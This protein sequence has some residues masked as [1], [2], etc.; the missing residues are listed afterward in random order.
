ML[1]HISVFLETFKAQFSWRLSS[2][3]VMIAHA[4][5]KWCQVMESSALADETV[6]ESMLKRGGVGDTF[7]PG[8]VQCGSTY[9]QQTSQAAD[10]SCRFTATDLL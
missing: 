3:S 6:L 2:G 9:P 7:C 1:H 4:E 10:S 8:K 5:F